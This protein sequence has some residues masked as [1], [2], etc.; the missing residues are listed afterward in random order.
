VQR[1]RDGHAS[2]TLRQ[3]KLLA[4]AVDHLTP[5]APPLAPAQWEALTAAEATQQP[6]FAPPRES[7]GQG[8]V[9]KREPPVV[10]V[11]RE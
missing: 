10:D 3:L 8:G 6:P 5:G 11:K 9:V 4:A 7:Q 2:L 1:R